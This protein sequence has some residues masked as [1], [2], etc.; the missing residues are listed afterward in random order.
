MRNNHNYNEAKKFLD[1][2]SRDNQNEIFHFQTF[3]DLKGAKR[4]SLVKVLVGT[5][6]EH[7]DEMVHLNNQGAG[8]FVCIN[9]VED[10]KKREA[11]SI[12]KI[13]AVFADK[14]DGAF[15]TFPV[16][17]SIIVQTK[18]GQHA[19]WL[20]DEVP[21][22]EF[23]TIQKSI[24]NILKTDI[25]I[26]DL[27]RVMRLPGFFH[28][29]DPND[30][31]LV[32]VL[33][34]N[35][36]KY[37]LNDLN[38][39]FPK[40]ETKITSVSSIKGSHEEISKYIEK[41]DGAI[42]GENGDL[43]T[44]QIAC[45]LIRGFNL[46]IEEALLYFLK[47]NEKCI[48]SWT[49]NELI[50]KL[51]NAR[52]SGTGEFGYLLKNLTT[53]QWVYRFIHKN[54]VKTTYNQKIYFRDELITAS[55]LVRKAEIQWDCEGRKSKINI[56]K[57]IF[58]EW[59]SESRKNILKRVR[60]K[61]KFNP[62][63][64]GVCSEDSL[65]KFTEALVGKECAKFNQHRAVI[66]HFIWQVK[67]KIFGYDVVH[68]MCPVLVGKQGCGKTQALEH[69]I[70]P[71][72]F[73]STEGNL[74]TFVRESEKFVFGTYYIVKLDEFAKGAKSDLE[75][76]K[77]IITSSDIN[78]RTFYVQKMA[79]LHNISTFIGASNRS[80]SEIFSDPTGNRRF[81]EIPCLDKIDW[82]VIGGISEDDGIDYYNL[83][84]SIDEENESPI[85]PFIAEISRYQEEFRPT[86]I[87]EDWLAS[88]DLK[89]DEESETEIIAVK[90]LHI[91]FMN[92]LKVQNCNFMFTDQKFG[93]ELSK[94]LKREKR[95]DG[96]YYVVKVR[97]MPPSSQ[98]LIAYHGMEKNSLDMTSAKNEID[99]FVSKAMDT[100]IVL[101]P[102]RKS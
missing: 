51:E 71:L 9:K 72:K 42:Q 80:V 37:S 43:K 12:S 19:Y 32:T 27:S 97:K 66:G 23:T 77:N 58:E 6:E 34:N 62:K 22:C 53:E 24:I 11:K 93:R 20:T 96:T 39:A 35:I 55:A 38:S 1:T 21:K 87:V 90:K 81:Y 70:R 92:W 47:Y 13:R 16:E 2:L 100:P 41:L 89:P 83:W 74:G 76:M 75:S 25:S 54:N 73:L 33:K 101:H 60:E 59:E 48:P 86:T 99:D 95:N 61:F 28:R 49:K 94:L 29:K 14:D 67:R 18:N 91:D 68:H 4:A 30:A 36:I 102:G 45:D 84:M 5:L 10:T 50:Q 56:I 79:T 64:S 85:M 31:H 82:G 17:P 98:P 57:S 78:Y 52:K 26:H 65:S 7:F 15:S 8:V 3:D 44:F 40:L 69:L 46:E 88:E 63:Y